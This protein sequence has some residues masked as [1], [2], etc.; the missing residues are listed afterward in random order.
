[1]VQLLTLDGAVVNN[2]AQ[3]LTALFPVKGDISGNIYN[4]KGEDGSI[5]TATSEYALGGEGAEG[6]ALPDLL[7]GSVPDGIQEILNKA[8]RPVSGEVTDV[9][10]LHQ[11]ESL[12]ETIVGIEATLALRRPVS[13]IVVVGFVLW[14]FQS[15]RWQTVDVEVITDEDEPTEQG[16]I[17]LELD[18]TGGNGYARRY[19]DADGR[20]W[21]RIWTW[22]FGDVFGGAPEYSILWDLMNVQFLDAGNDQPG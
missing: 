5:L 7:D 6:Y 15:R 3:N 1:M 14:D 9:A 18:V 11:V 10:L 12:P 16:N 19:I 17:E 21:A 2:Q 8:I 13:P 22:G 4:V 20:N